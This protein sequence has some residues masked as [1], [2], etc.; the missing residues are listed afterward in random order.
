[1]KTRAAALTGPKQ[2]WEILEFDLDDPHP[3]EVLVR[4]KVAGLCHTDKHMKYSAI[5]YPLVG[6]HE[7]AGVVEAVGEA[8]TRV[9]VG[10]HVAC[11]WIPTCG[12]CRFCARGQSNLC[13]LGANQLTGEL[14]NGGFRFHLD[15]VGIGGMSATG[16]FSERVVLDQRSVIKIDQSIPFEWASLV[17][18]GVATGWGSVVNAGNVRAGDSVAIFGCGG[19]GSNSVSAAVDANADLVA[20][21]DPVEFKRTFAKQLGADL[22]YASAAEAHGEVVERTGGI[23]VDVTIVT[24]GVVDSEIVRAA[25]EITRKGG[26]IVLTGVADDISENTIVLPGSMLTVFNKRI[27][28]TLYGGCNPVADIPMLLGM[29]KH[30]KLDLDALVTNRYSLDQIN[31]GFRDML[32]GRNIRGLIVHDE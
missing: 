24:A 19:I 29:A 1:M 32:E 8:V 6:G 27:V 23:G 7:G 16:T 31:E 30:G 12:V 28:G 2:D 5:A 11:S 15:G 3:G 18:C 14:A 20:V 10:D 22:V 9:A 13:A 17:S 4:M 26:T 21:I 25:F